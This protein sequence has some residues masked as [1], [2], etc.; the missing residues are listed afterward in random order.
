MRYNAQLNIQLLNPRE[1][2]TC[3][4][5]LEN[6]SKSYHQASTNVGIKQRSKKDYGFLWSM[7]HH[8]IAI[9]FDKTI[10]SH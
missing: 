4:R 7:W 5:F 6:G 3:T 10:P 1:T 2:F 8:G 9:N